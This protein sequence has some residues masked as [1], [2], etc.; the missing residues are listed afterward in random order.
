[1]WYGYAGQYAIVDLTTGQVSKIPLTEDMARKFVGGRGF[2]VN[3]LY[4]RV[5]P[6]MDAFAPEMPL[7]FAVG[8]LTGTIAP[9]S[10]RWTVGCK[11]PQTGLIT[12]GIGGGDFGAHLKWAGFD[13]VII[14]GRSLRPVYLMISDGNIEIVSAEHLWGKDTTEVEAAIRAEQE[15][16]NIHVAAIGLAGENL[17]PTTTII[18]DRARSAGRGGAGAVMGSKNLKAVAVYGRNAVPLYDAKSAL[19]EAAR[20]T[21]KL[22]TEAHFSTYLEWG[23]TYFLDRYTQAGGLMSFNAQRGIFP[24]WREMDGRVY[25][26]KHWRGRLACYGCPLPC[27]SYFQ[28][29]KGLRGGTFG[30]ATSASTLKELGARVGVKDLRHILDCHVEID[31]LGLDLISAPATIA[32]AVEAFQKGIL[33]KAATGGLPLEFGRGDVVL[34]LLRR[35]ARREGIGEDLAHGSRACAER[36]GKGS[37]LLRTDSKGLEPPATDPR[38]YPAWALGYA[39]SS[40]G[41]CHMRA[42]SVFE[43]GG[44][45]EDQAERMGVPMSVNER[46]EWR[47]K[48]RGVAFFE[49]LRSLGD[50]LI[51]CRFVARNALAFPEEQVGILNAVTGLGF[52]AKDLY[53]VGERITNLERLF[54]LREGLRPEDDTLPKRFL[55]EP[56]PDGPS[57]GCVV[58]LEPMLEEYYTARSWDRGTG[59]P[60]ADKLRELGLTEEYNGEGETKP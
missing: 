35:M 44:V 12:I 57:A 15:N 4:E 60:S 3:W 10:G 34:E 16:W 55:Q 22:M 39:T 21:R 27:S 13:A 33:T 1:M 32:F 42:Y 31:R 43:F 2:I 56:L 24:D 9:S 45:E 48:G 20:M 40:R 29:E 50:S 52:T 59:E 49:D 7:I 25:K 37:D 54:N 18:A 19:D 17:A 5:T 36:W 6:R 41:G 28:V 26:E 58:P 47:G 11:A 51:T 23:T 30:E 8:P 46:L 53:L 14:V 38:A